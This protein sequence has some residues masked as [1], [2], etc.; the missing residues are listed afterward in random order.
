ML[1]CFVHNRAAVAAA[2]KRAGGSAAGVRS[3]DDPHSVAWALLGGNAASPMPLGEVIARE[4]LPAPKYTA[5][6]LRCGSS[7]V[8]RGRR[9]ACQNQK[10]ENCRLAPR[11][12]RLPE[13]IGPPWRHPGNRKHRCA[14]AREH[15]R[16]YGDL[17]IAAKDKAPANLS[18]AQRE[19]LR[20][21]AYAQK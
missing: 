10:T 11:R 19:K 21:F 12:I 13:Q 7:P 5:M 16:K 15:L 9:A 8:N 6:A 2:A 3:L 1:G 20:E 4:I 18:A 17:A 14:L